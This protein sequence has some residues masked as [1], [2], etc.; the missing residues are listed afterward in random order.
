MRKFDNANKFTGCSARR[1]SIS[2]M[3]T[4]R[5]ASGEILGHARYK[6]AHINTVYQSSNTA[7][8]DHRNSCFMIGSKK[9]TGTIPTSFIQQVPPSLYHYPATVPYH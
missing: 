9:N 7:M 1:L 6:S 5:I 3:A 8:F 2:K 4:S